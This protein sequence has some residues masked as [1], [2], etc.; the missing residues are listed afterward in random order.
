MKR[1]TVSINEEVGEAAEAVAKERGL[2][3]SEF[4]AQ[5]VE[6]AVDE[7]KRQRALERIEEEGM[8]TGANVSRE[9][10]DA[11]QE[12]MRHDDMRR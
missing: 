3:V 2:S 7:Y 1:V 6:A 8:G 11:A 4:Y 10:F 12:V 5:A 9:E